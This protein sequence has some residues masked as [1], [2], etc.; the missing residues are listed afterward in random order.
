[1]RKQRGSAGDATFRIVNGQTVMS[2]KITTNKSKSFAQMARRVR[3]ANIVNF[4]QAM[5]GLDRPSFETKPR[6]WSDFNAF[7]SANIDGAPV[8]LTKEEAGQGACVVPAY[9]VTRGSLPSIDVAAGT[10]GVPVSDIALGNLVIDG[11]TTLKEFSDAVV[12][13]NTNYVQGDQISCFIAVQEQNPVTGIPYINFKAYEVTLNQRDE[14]TL[15]ADIV[16]ADGFSSVDGKLGASGT[17][18]GGICWV[19]SRKGSNRV[20]V[21][22]QSLFVNNALLAQYQTSAKRVEAIQSYGGQVSQLFLVPNTDMT[23]AAA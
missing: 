5:K 11:D 10:G 12:D 9:Q 20:M 13:N 22:T 8:Y 14:D 18:N 6:T 23:I 21:S 4:W 17:V 2:E 7:M 3:W 1:M 15:L 16:S 19:H